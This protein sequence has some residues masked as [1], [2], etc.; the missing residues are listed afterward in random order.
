MVAFFIEIKRR[1]L[2]SPWNCK[3]SRTAKTRRR[4][5]IRRLTISDFEAYH[6]AIKTETLWYG[7]KDRQGTQLRAPGELAEQT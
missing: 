2:E 3:K 5:K 6:K 7:Y 1:I 4:V